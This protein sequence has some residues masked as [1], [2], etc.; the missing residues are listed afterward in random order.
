MSAWMRVFASSAAEP[1]P[2]IVLAEMRRLG[3]TAPV[4]FHGDDQGWFRAVLLSPAEK[5]IAELERYLST[6]DGVRSELNTWAAWLETAAPERPELPGRVV[7]AGQVFTLQFLGDEEAVEVGV[8]LCRFLARLTDGIYQVDGQG[9]F[10]ADGSLLVG[11]P[12]Q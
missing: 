9:F 8:E 6:E 5:P 12:P 4:R 3:L 1:P 2:N 11:E 7:T 10:S